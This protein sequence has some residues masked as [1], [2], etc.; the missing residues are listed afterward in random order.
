MSLNI[1]TQCAAKF[2]FAPLRAEPWRVV[3]FQGTGSTLKLVDTQEEEQ[4]LEELIDSVKGDVP[5]EV[6]VHLDYLL[7]TPFRYPPLKYGSRFGTIRE[8]SIWYGSKALRTALAERAYYRLLFLEG[9]TAVLEPLVDRVTAFRAVVASLR[10][11]DLTRPP[12][13]VFTDAISSPVTYE[14]SQALGK[15]LREVG[16]EAFLFE[17]ARDPLEGINVGLFE[18]VFTSPRPSSQETWTCVA[19][20]SLVAFSR[21]LPMGAPQS[22]RFDRDIFIVD[23]ALPQPG[24]LG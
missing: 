7:F 19:R 23:G 21:D 9:T 2:E 24:A 22:E 8:R 14:H 18:P 5:K 10:C 11:A 17:S 16:V 12:F 4:L 15:A 13:D 1:W 3:E 20:K 6:P